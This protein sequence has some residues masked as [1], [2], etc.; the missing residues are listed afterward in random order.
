MRERFGVGQII[1]RDEVN[2]LVSQRR[3][4]DVAPDPAETIDANFDSHF[5]SPVQMIGF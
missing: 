5:S 3:P 1:N 2:L 4:Q